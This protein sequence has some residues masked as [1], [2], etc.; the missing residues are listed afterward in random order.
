LKASL[1]DKVKREDTP[2][3]RAD[4]SDSSRGAR[5]EWEV[6]APMLMFIV[7]I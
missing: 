5:M 6:I 2:P 7:L 1:E 3:R 4:Q